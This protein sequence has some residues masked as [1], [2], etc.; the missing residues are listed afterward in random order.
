MSEENVAIVYEAYDAWNRGEF[1]DAVRRFA[2]EEI[3]LHII[4]GFEDLIGEA[5]VGRDRVVS[6]WREL[7][8]T[9]RLQMTVERVYDADEQVV[10]T[11]TQ[12]ALG[13]ESGAPTTLRPGQVW[14]FREGKVIRVDSYYTWENALEAAG[15]S[16]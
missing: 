4:G 14:T 9:L 6:V 10:V 2:S 13:A 3:E 11:L 15:L 12:R 1:D 8:G 5:F 16:E 7:A